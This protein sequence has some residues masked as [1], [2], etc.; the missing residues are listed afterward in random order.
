MEPSWKKVSELTFGSACSNT[1]KITNFFTNE[2]KLGKVVSRYT[3]VSYWFYLCTP[4][5]EGLQGFLAQTLT[6]TAA[7]VGSAD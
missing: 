6:R 7:T 1:K 3:E 4:Q 2:V 5:I